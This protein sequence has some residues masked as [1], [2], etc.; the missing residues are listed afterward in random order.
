LAF[1]TIRGRCKAVAPYPTI[2]QFTPTGEGEDMVSDQV[3]ANSAEAHVQTVRDL[4][5]RGISLG[6]GPRGSSVELLGYTTGMSNPRARISSTEGGP[7]NTLGAVARFVWL[8][9]GSDRLEDIAYYEPRVRSYTDDGLTVPGSS[10]GKRL[11]NSTPGTNQIAGV[12][13]E[14]TENPSSRRAAAVVWL[15]EDAV[16]M[17]N[18]IPC[19]FGLFFH[20][21]GGGLIMTTVM[22]S[23]NAITLLPYNFFEFSMLGEIVAAELGVPFVKYV[24]WA[25]SMHIFDEASAS[26]DKILGITG[27]AAFEMPEM[28]CGDALSQGLRLAKFE[29]ALRHASTVDAVH[30]V[31][32]AAHKELDAYWGALFDVLYAYGLAK[33]AERAEAISTLEKLPDYLKLGA[34]RTIS[35]TLEELLGPVRPGESV[36]D[37]ALFSLSDLQALN[38]PGAAALVAGAP[39]QAETGGTD[40]LLNTLKELSNHGRPVTLDEMF[41]VREMLVQDD[42]TL[43]A[44]GSDSAAE[45]S[46]GDVAFALDAIREKRGG[47]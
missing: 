37:D 43:A 13:R 29:S 36:V 45:L 5:E 20:V 26:R 25:A 27:P 39:F 3:P 19:T 15:P 6:D 21:R 22:R 41:A 16:R 2:H 10:Y 30:S 8:L 46:A 28:P 34:T 12:V 11:F 47:S 42:V 7:L 23:N 38:T 40:W 32:A 14:L 17:S 24:H 33:R 44:R 18:D 35:R 4:S 31:A 1:V 9:A